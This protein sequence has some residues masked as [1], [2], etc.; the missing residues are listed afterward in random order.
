MASCTVEILQQPKTV[1]VYNGEVAT[2]VC[3]ANAEFINWEINGDPLSA[4]NSDGYINESTIPQNIS[5]MMNIRLSTLNIRGLTTN[6]RSNI[7]CVAFLG[8]SRDQS[9]IAVLNVQGIII[10]S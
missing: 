9:V 6:N 3:I 1:T 4:P 2:F 7:T 10:Y 5:N 8:S